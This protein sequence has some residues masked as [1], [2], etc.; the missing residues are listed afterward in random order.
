[1]KIRGVR[2]E[3][4]AV[5]SV[6]LAA[7][8]P[9]ITRV[10]AVPFQSR[11]VA[12]IEVAREGIPWGLAPGV[13]IPFR[14]SMGSNSNSNGS[15]SSVTL[16]P[17]VHKGNRDTEADQVRAVLMSVRA[18]C[19]LS[20]PAPVA[21]ARVLVIPTM[22]VTP[23]GKASR[24]AI[25]MM[26]REQAELELYSTNGTSSSSVD[27]NVD[28][29]WYAMAGGWA[30]RVARAWAEELQL[31]LNMIGID[32]DFTALG[33]DSLAALRVCQ[34]LSI[35]ARPPGFAPADATSTAPTSSIGSGSGGAGAGGGSANDTWG[36]ALGAFMPGHLIKIAVLSS[37]AEHIHRNFQHHHTGDDGNGECGGNKEGSIS[38]SSGTRGGA[39]QPAAQHAVDSTGILATAILCAAGS[40]APGLLKK[41]VELAA[42]YVGDGSVHDTSFHAPAAIAAASSELGKRKQGWLNKALMAAA[43]SGSAPCIAILL[44]AGASGR[45]AA[46]L[47]SGGNRASALHLA[48]QSSSL[49]AVR[50]LVEADRSLLA[51]VDGDKQTVVHR[52]A[53][54]G[55]GHKM[56]GFLID[57]LVTGANTGKAGGGGGRKSGKGGGGGGGGSGGG[58][59]VRTPCLDKDK[60]GRTPLHWAV[61]NGHTTAVAALLEHNANAAKS[62][63]DDGGETPLQVAE[64]RAQ[65]KAQDRPDGLRP[66]VFGNI[67]TQL[68]GMAKT[69]R[70]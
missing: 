22:P 43:T 46:A 24:R 48:V 19:L 34:C 38:D 55:A 21:P 14:N 67:A 44:A 26:F 58:G 59:S 52:G 11:L 4:S 64:R 33:G 6:I 9:V 60:W 3:A 65:C 16:A 45:A 7:F 63:P 37:Y 53:R 56:L 12:A 5:E 49:D 31:P 18:A 35:E 27:G 23:S 20:L 2:I 8:A 70:E 40:S 17:S 25:L 62:L 51:A 68:G 36:E 1:M 10:T 57:Q 32:S 15:S 29:E 28:A 42:G 54:T 47:G 13:T 39:V 61:V 41:L 66:S 69:V 30:G 50:T